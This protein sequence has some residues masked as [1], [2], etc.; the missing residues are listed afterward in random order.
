MKVH[1]RRGQAVEGPDFE[2]FFQAE[3]R[4]LVRALYLITA[5]QFEAEELAQETMAR[6]YERWDRV[7]SMESPGGYV[8]RVAVNLNRHRLRHLAVRA[9]RLLA[10][11][12]QL[13]SSQ[14]ETRTEIADAIASLS[15]GQRN[16]F[17][18]VEWLGMSSEEAGRIL[19]IEPSSVRSRVHRAR[20]VL[21][22]RLSDEGGH[23]G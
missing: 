3:Y 23:D 15:V 19:R 22:D 6:M 21:R 10:L 8:Y 14:S 4:G 11:H 13:V 7:R 17:L 5:D 9:R 16:A 18:L 1:I 2:E 12:P 20:A